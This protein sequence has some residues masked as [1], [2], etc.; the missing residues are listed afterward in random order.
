MSEK[1]ED[2]TVLELRKA[3]KE[4]GVKLGAGISKQGIVEKL[5]A[6][7]VDR[8]EP[9]AAP[10]TPPEAAP[11]APVRRASI[12][13]DDGMDDEDDLALPPRPA[14]PER[15][16][17][18][19]RTTGMG[20]ASSL[21]TISAKAPAFTMEGSR[22]WHN[23]RT[24]SGS[25]Y[26]RPAPGTWNSR[27]AGE[28]H[29]YSSRT[30]VPG[31]SPVPAR[32]AYPQRFGPEQMEQ[33]PRAP[34]SAPAP[35][36]YRDYQP[37]GRPQGGYIRRE[38]AE[39]PQP[40]MNE[41]L[42]AGE[43]GDA[44]G[45]LEIQPEGYGFLRA[46]SP[47]G[48]DVYISA[49][50]IRRFSL[51]SGDLVTGKTRPQRESDRTTAMLYITE[52]NNQSPEE[53]AKRVPFESLTAL[54]PA[55]RIRLTARGHQDPFLRL[56]ELLCPLGF[57]QR[58][59]VRV[60]A[61]CDGRAALR[62]MANAMTA[63]NSKAQ[64][65]VVL[66]DEKPEDVSEARA[67]F[68][69]DLLIHTADQPVEMLVR[70]AE[71]ALE[72][73]QRLVEQQTDVVL[74]VGDIA[75]LC[76]A[77]G[78]MMPAAARTLPSG[79]IAGGMNKPRRFFGAARNTKEAGSLTVIAFCPVPENDPAAEAAEKE[80]RGLAN[81]EMM[82]LPGVGGVAPGFDL[83]ASRGLRSD[84]LL[85][86]AE[87]AVARQIREDAAGTEA[88]KVLEQL[89]GL[90]EKTENNEALVALMSGVYSTDPKE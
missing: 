34:Y 26:Q 45:T 9:E 13:A 49:A 60:P 76:D 22:A 39:T 78:Q 73:A 61:G 43:C 74:L 90:T 40:S 66:T 58:A 67:A 24:Y 68:R 25:T 36:D 29:T 44:T 56:T 71:N 59:L 3:A 55:K 6:A 15:P 53:A 84:T 12:I 35:Q 51:R 11:A 41:L 16:V 18:P 64:T 46:D 47:N 33:E 81:W 4:M 32:P 80:L 30:P 79:L 57:G 70:T 52:I 72:R 2:M 50:Q 83:C 77:C 14:Q 75:K 54:Y 7:A 42:M 21:S 88:G 86:E 19:P 65:L 20:S 5:T 8:P 69:A 82:L 48:K 37:A 28:M 27:P 87:A 10:E 31:R 1:F 63:F 85:T 17:I 23:P 62:K 38:S 89:A